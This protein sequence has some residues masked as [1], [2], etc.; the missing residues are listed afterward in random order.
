MHKPPTKVVIFAFQVQVLAPSSPRSDDAGEKVHHLFFFLNIWKTEA[1]WSGANVQPS[2]TCG[3]FQ[4]SACIV[5]VQI[6]YILTAHFGLK[7]LKDWILYFYT[8]L[9]LDL[10]S[11]GGFVCAG[12][13]DLWTSL[14]IGSLFLL[15]GS[16]GFHIVPWLLQDIVHAE[17]EKRKEPGQVSC[18]E[19]PCLYCLLQSRMLSSWYANFNSSKD[20]CMWE[21][22]TN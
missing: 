19:K 8:R 11:R 16:N 13:L 17:V 18:V 7:L 15:S 3:N 9:V 2:R 10:F 14:P 20:S 1:D 5:D 21:S 4:D 12:T 6:I 22:E